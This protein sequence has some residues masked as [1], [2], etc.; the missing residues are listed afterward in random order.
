MAENAMKTAKAK[1]NQNKSPAP[2]LTVKL[3]SKKPQTIKEFP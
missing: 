1:E 3:R 2:I